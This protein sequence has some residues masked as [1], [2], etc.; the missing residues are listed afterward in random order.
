MVGLSSQKSARIRQPQ[1]DEYFLL[2]KRLE[3]EL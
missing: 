3:Q 1:G 2:G